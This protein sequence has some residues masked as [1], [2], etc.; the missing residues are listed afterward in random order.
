[1]FSSLSSLRRIL[2]FSEERSYYIDS[3]TTPTSMSYQTD[4]QPLINVDY[5]IVSKDI[6]SRIKEVLSALIHSDQSG[7]MKGLSVKI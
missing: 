3:K 6:V 7:F 4:A 5:K 1:M 2:Y